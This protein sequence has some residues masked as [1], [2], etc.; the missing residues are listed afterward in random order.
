M[1]MKIKASAI[2]LIAVIALSLFGWLVHSQIGGLQNQIDQLQTQVSDLQDQNSTLQDQIGKLQN[3][4]SEQQLRLSEITYALALERPLRVLITKFKW[5]GDFNPI[6]GLAIG[7]SVNVT[8]QNTDV[9]AVSG[10]TLTVRLLYKG[11][12][13]EVKDSRG[14]SKHI[15]MLNAGESREVTGEVIATLDSF[16]TASAAC[17]IRLSVNDVALDEGTYNLS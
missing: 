2:V 3:Q 15:D 16:S 8:V 12:L 5:I 14:F 17:A 7:Y 4:N 9:I 1:N 13:I 10:L 6:G 11:T